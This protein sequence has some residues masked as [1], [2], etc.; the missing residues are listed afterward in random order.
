[1][2]SNNRMYHNEVRRKLQET[3]WAV[4]LLLLIL[5]SP[6]SQV[7]LAAPISDSP[8][9]RQTSREGDSERVKGRAGGEGVKREGREGDSEKEG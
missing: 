4:P 8:W 3:C 9:V 5:Y 1:M 2:Y 6:A 7:W